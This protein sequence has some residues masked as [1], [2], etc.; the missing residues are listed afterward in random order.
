MSPSI[1]IVLV[2]QCACP[3]PAQEVKPL[4]IEGHTDQLSDRPGEAVG[5]LV[6]TTAR[7]YALEQSVRGPMTL[8]D[9][10]ARRATGP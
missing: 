4:F 7:T 10:R 1:A 6:S 2:A 8:T 5:F 3:V 9:R